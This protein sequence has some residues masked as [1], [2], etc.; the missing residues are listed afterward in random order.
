MFGTGGG[1]DS[2]TAVWIRVRLTGGFPS[3]QGRSPNSQAVTII[4]MTTG[5]KR[6][7]PRLTTRQTTIRNVLLVGRV[8]NMSIGGLGIETTTGLRIGSRHSFSV[9]F[10]E[11]PVGIEAEIR[12][13]RLTQTIGKGPGEVAAIYRAG[14]S[15]TR[16]LDL[17]PDG[18]LKNNGGWFD[19]EVRV[20][21]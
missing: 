18:G 17:F 12:W 10:A 5:E 19:P 16:T 6:Q 4:K 13:C 21:R 7:H 11:K 8:L 14:L 15:F 2:S 9:I 3:I 20:S 1:G